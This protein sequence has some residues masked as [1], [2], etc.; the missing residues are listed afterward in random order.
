M[1][2]Q[3]A[4][5]SL[6]VEAVIESVVVALGGEMKKKQIV[7]FFV[8]GILLFMFGIDVLS[9]LGLTFAEVV[10]AWLGSAVSALIGAVL[11]FRWSGNIND[12]LDWVNG[13]RQP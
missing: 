11:A 12:I 7:A 10:P 6:L 2:E 9:F 4:I 13:G 5:V 3:L 8:G 1:F